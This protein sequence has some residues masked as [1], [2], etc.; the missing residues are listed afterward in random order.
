MLNPSGDSLLGLQDSLRVIIRGKNSPN[1]LH[2]QYVSTLYSA[3]LGRTVDPQGSEFWANLIIQ[4][5]TRS[6][7]ALGIEYS[8]EGRIALVQNLYQTYLQ[9][10]VD[11]LGLQGSLN[12]LGLGGTV[13]QLKAI[14]IDS[15]EYF[16]N[17]AGGTKGGFLAAV[18]R[19]VLG[20]TVDPVGALIFGQALA[21]GVSRFTIASTLIKSLEAEQIHLESLYLVYLNRPADAA[22]A[23][24]FLDARRVG[25][26][27]ETLLAAILGSDE[28]FSRI[29]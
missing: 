8:P 14:I 18:Y 15:Q 16:Q 28:F 24:F 20:R 29:E 19:D 25:A 9:R 4:G 11:L 13:E 6:V 2:F 23:K 7:V 27:D 1:D 22:G 3:L 17:R 26:T 10:A 21:V 5:V 12:F